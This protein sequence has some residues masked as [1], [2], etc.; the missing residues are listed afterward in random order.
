MS[1]LN[2]FKIDF[3]S[4]TEL[5]WLAVEILFR[6]QRLIQLTREKGIDNIEIEFLT[7][8]YLLPQTVEMK[9]PIEDF[10]SIINE[11]KQALILAYE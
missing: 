1:V 3:V 2:E 6:G 8:M 5:E 11:A 10:I 9:F 4:Q 7:D